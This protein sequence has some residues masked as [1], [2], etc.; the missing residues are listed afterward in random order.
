MSKALI[1]P[2]CNK[3]AFIAEKQFTFQV[4]S[5]VTNWEIEKKNLALMQGP[6]YY[7]DF[8]YSVYSVITYR[9]PN[10]G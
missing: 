8:I 10:W 2:K 6:Q 1:H 7:L 3:P 4:R 9:N 5:L